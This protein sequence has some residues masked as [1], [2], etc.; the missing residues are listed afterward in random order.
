MMQKGFIAITSVIIIAS[1]VLAIS[2]SATYLSIGEGQ[3]ALSLTEGEHTLNQVES[4]VEEALF[5]IRQSPTYAG[6]TLNH[7]D[8]FSCLINVV[9]VANNYTV[10]VTN[11]NSDYTRSIEV[12]ANRTG[13]LS[14]TSW[15]E[16]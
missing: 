10:T 13:Q 15:K 11:L 8:G 4:C 3:S 14:I 16:I 7:P 9:R 2:L 1:V 12:A 6:G 5:K